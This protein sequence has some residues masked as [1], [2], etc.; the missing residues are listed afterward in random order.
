MHTYTNTY[1]LT[2]IHTCTHTNTYIH[3]YTHTHTRTHTHTHTHTHLQDFRG[4][5]EA[6]E[7]EQPQRL[8]HTQ[9]GELGRVEGRLRGGHSRLG[10]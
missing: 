1:I 4:T 7:L 5:Q 8:E 6:K 3:T 9:Q 10:A 2:Y